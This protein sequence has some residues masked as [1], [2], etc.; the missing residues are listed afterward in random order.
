MP[1]KY[2]KIRGVAEGGMVIFQGSKWTW[3]QTV[4]RDVCGILGECETSQCG[5]ILD[6]GIR[7]DLI[8]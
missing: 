6:S 5:D 2:G 3:S 4:C 1:L 8:N 7:N